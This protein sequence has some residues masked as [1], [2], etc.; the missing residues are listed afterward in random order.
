[1]YYIDELKK[2]KNNLI[3]LNNKNVIEDLE[4][5]KL[6]FDYTNQIRELENDLADMNEELRHDCF[7]EILSVLII[8]LGVYF[9]LKN[10]TCSIFLIAGGTGF[11]FMVIKDIK[12]IIR[13]FKAYNEYDKL[14]EKVDEIKSNSK[15]YKKKITELETKIDDISLII[16]HKDIRK[17]ENILKLENTKFAK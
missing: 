15:E 4:F 14:I 10:S 13:Y 16:E 8:S 7:I 6:Y 11:I 12:M 17:A 3:I 5:Q 9:S 2:L 1:M